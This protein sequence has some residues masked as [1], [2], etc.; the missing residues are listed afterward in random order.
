MTGD[1]GAAQE[2]IGLDQIRTP[3]GGGGLLLGPTLPGLAA[4][5]GVRLLRR[6]LRLGKLVIAARA[7]HVHEVLRRDLDFLIAPANAQRIEAVDGPFILGMDRGDT[8]ARERRALYSALAAVDI[9]AIVAASAVDADTLIA[10]A[11]EGPC[12]AVGGYARVVAGRTAAR[13][14]GV[15]GP[16]EATFLEVA[17]A[18][19]AHTFLNITGDKAIEA[20]A[21][22]AA[23]LMRAWL[24]AEIARRRGLGLTGVDLMG[25]LMGEAG[26]DD[27]GVRRTLGGMLVGAVD[28]TASAVAK[29]LAVFG[30]DPRLHAAARRD[31]ADTDLTLGWCREALRR[32]PHNPLVQRGTL[33]DTTLEGVAVP[34]GSR[35]VAW[36]QAAMLDSS[37]FPDPGRMRPDRPAGAYLHFGGGLHPC[38]GRAVNDLQIPMLVS[39]LLKRGIARVG[40]VEWAGPFP[41]RL[42]LELERR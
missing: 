23:L 41:D 16:D 37:A 35:V 8:L 22:K 24:S 7:R 4:W 1:A 17:R 10:A 29:I 31:C 19:F 27:E 40:R 28:T 2:P 21:L 5:I 39:A 14:F 38:A 36:T 18:I 11:G 12:D 32:W 20:R 9:P 42:P 13:L 3:R 25:A 33:A 26:L 30:A 15:G 6:P 34:A